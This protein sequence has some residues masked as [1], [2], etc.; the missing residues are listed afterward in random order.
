LLLGVSCL[1]G[2]DRL[3]VGASDRAACTIMVWSRSID[4]LVAVNLPLV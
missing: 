4:D 3:V 1:E 2:A